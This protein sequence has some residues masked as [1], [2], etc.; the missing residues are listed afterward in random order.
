MRPAAP[1]S[2]APSRRWRDDGVVLLVVV[3]GLCATALVH[4]SMREAEAQRLHVRTEAAATEVLGRVEQ[5]LH[6]TVEAVRNAAL[7][8]EVQPGLTRSAFMHYA[9]Q[10][11]G[12]LPAVGMLEW[13]PL[14]PGDE[15]ESFER[16]A[17]EQGLPGFEIKE[18]SDNG[19]SWQPAPRRERYV[20]I[21]YGWPEGKSPLGFNLGDDPVRMA[22][23]DE[24]AKR[25]RPLASGSFP[26]LQQDI[27]GGGAVTG[28]AITAPVMELTPGPQGQPIPRGFLAAV[29]ELPALFEP[30]MVEA[31]RARMNLWLYEGRHMGAQPVLQ[32]AGAP[33]QPAGKG[34][35]HALQRVSALDVAGRAWTLVQQPQPAWLQEGTGSLPAAM[36]GLGLL[37]SALLG[38]AVHRVLRERALAHSARA[39]LARERQRLVDVLDGTRAA[40]WEHDFT[41]G[42]THVN[43]HWESLAGYAPGEHPI[44]PGYHW[45]NDCHPDD[46]PAVAEA[47]RRHF[48]GET[49][50]Y[51]MEYRHRHKT[52][53]W[54]WVLARAK[55]LTRDAEGRPQLMAGTLVDVQ[56]RKEAEAR[57]QALNATLEARVEARTAE[58]TRALASL[59]E[60]REA[61]ARTE[62]RATLDTLVANVAQQLQT[63]LGNSRIAVQNLSD[64]SREL[65]ARLDQPMR[66]R[67]LQDFVDH[68]QANAEL[69]QRNLTRAA[70]L[71]D[72]FRQVASAP[73]GEQARSIDLREWLGALSDTLTHSQRLQP[74]RLELDVPDDLRLMTTPGL[75]GQVLTQLLQHL[76]THAFPADHGGGCLRLRAFESD[77]HLILTLGDDGPGLPPDSSSGLFAP[78]LR[79]TGADG[80]TPLGLAIADQ[81][82]RQD[83]GGSLRVVGLP[84]PGPRFEIRLPLNASAAH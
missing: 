34:D 45:R 16:R 84:G 75:L 37:V 78:I 36:L 58:L 24:A 40:A 77:G 33:P 27:G 70:H 26:I 13:Q 42:E 44:G 74:H 12:A 23:K 65:H 67:E 66:R 30:V 52:Q 79:R 10:L 82:L 59:T 76:A 14:V 35:L 19:S 22:S 69:A 72:T 39:N 38:T 28:F 54:V 50:A 32:S 8:V 41:S 15:R 48:A 71:L 73:I 25:G 80:R 7:M 29:V 68:V 9:N 1:R 46:A 51:E 20:P 60:S 31:R 81:L 2:D 61:L 83:L 18:P 56:A 5:Q 55:V 53:G 11:A 64:R 17:R 3:L 21:L 63:P 4:R 57:L 43:A 62:V 47:L 49:E 6:R